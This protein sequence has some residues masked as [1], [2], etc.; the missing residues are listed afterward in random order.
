MAVEFARGDTKSEIL[1][2]CLELARQLGDN[3]DRMASLIPS[4]GPLR[5][6][7]FRE[8]RI[9]FESGPRTAVTDDIDLILSVLPSYYYHNTGLSALK[10][11]AGGK[12]LLP[13]N[14]HLIN[15][16]VTDKGVSL[17]LILSLLNS[18]GIVV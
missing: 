13:L 8:D 12:S 6:S 9:I 10:A 5:S 7:Q 16:I 15:G 4:R 17:H 3:A 11:L 1:R 2:E 14:E 18:L